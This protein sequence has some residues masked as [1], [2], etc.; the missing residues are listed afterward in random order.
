MGP[1]SVG[2]TVSTEGTSAEAGVAEPDDATAGIAS[3]AG[4]AFGEAA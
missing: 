2:S 4:S 1:N 3:A